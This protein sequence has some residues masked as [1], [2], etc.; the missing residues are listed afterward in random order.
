MK[1]R[2]RHLDPRGNIVFCNLDESDKRAISVISTASQ[3]LEGFARGG[4]I[5]NR[6]GE[7]FV[8]TK[9]PDLVKSSKKFKFFCET[10]A[11]MV[12]IFIESQSDYLDD[13]TANTNRLIHNL[14]TLNAHNLQNIY[15][16]LPQ[17]KLARSLG[18]SFE[19]FRSAV[20]EQPDEVARLLRNLTKNAVSTKTEFSVY[21]KLFEKKPSLQQRVHNVHK[22]L[23]N[24]LYVFF[25][26]FTDKRVKVNIECVGTVT[27]FF[28]YESIQVVF[29]HLIENAAKYV[30]NERPLAVAISS[31]EFGADIVFRMFSM[32]VDPE[33]CE[34]IFTEGF[35]GK[36][37]SISGKAGRGIGLDIAR[38]LVELNHGM[39]T[40]RSDPD[41]EE[42]H[43]GFPYQINEFC[44]SLPNRQNRRQM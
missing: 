38:R 32:K 19:V 42:E 28:D 5:T 34:S 36:Y 10:L 30:L 17:E 23:M 25:P 26:D 2:F 37:P 24:I 31:T 21:Q 8:F 40:F 33:E 11:E 20:I 3:R 22:V 13:L 1:V 39:I 29:H 18:K 41:S 4:H 35:S 14:T 7:T 43:F 16:V 27:A 6:V 9:D 12:G 15:S 44:V